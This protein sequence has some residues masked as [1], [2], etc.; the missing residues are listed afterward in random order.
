MD[1]Y[2]SALKRA[3]D[4]QQ[5]DAKHNEH[6]FAWMTNNYMQYSGFVPSDEMYNEWY[7]DENWNQQLWESI[8]I[9]INDQPKVRERK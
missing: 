1:I 3:I 9:Y 4:T 5:A 2:E 7:M 6:A 8:D